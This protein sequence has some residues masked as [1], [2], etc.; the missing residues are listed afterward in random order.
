MDTATKIE[1]R[2]LLLL[3]PVSLYV[4]EELASSGIFSLWSRH[5]SRVLKV[6]S[7]SGTQE[8]NEC[9]GFQEG[10]SRIGEDTEI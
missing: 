5:R 6:N 1:E 2:H 9:S 10:E 3:Q 7:S 8:S 4:G